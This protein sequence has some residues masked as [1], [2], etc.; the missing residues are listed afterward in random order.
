MRRVQAASQWPG[1]LGA[2]HALSCSVLISVDLKHGHRDTEIFPAGTELDSAE[3]LSSRSDAQRQ[4]GSLK[5]LDRF[6]EL[7]TGS[8]QPLR[9]RRGDTEKKP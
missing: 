8:C 6:Q 7:A 3:Y 5:A 1:N 4:Y 9:W 2:D